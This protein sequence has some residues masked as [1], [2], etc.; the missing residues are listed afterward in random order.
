LKESLHQLFSFAD[1][2]A[3]DSCSGNIEEW[4]SGFCRYSFGLKI[5]DLNKL[6]LTHKHSF[7]ISWRTKQ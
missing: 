7:P 1:P 6:T 3:H 2:F 5:K 4:T